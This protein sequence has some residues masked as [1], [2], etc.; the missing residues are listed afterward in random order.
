MGEKSAFDDYLDHNTWNPYRSELHIDPLEAMVAKAK[1]IHDKW[2]MNDV[3]AFAEQ[4][5]AIVLYLERRYAVILEAHETVATLILAEEKQIRPNGGKLK[6]PKFNLRRLKKVWGPLQRVEQLLC[7]ERS[8]E[9]EA[10]IKKH[11]G[12]FNSY[13]M[14]F[15]RERHMRTLQHGIEAGLKRNYWQAV[16]SAFEDMSAQVSEMRAARAEFYECHPIQEILREE[17]EDIRDPWFI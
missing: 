11:E 7:R 16:K 9:V 3:E 13:Y 6:D 2:H 17:Y 10:E 12:L 4:R 5:E 15:N 1:V 14:D 8:E